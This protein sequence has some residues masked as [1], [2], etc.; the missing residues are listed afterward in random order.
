MN[1]SGQG[2]TYFTIC[3]YEKNPKKCDPNLPTLNIILG[4]IFLIE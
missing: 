1:Q 3:E 2:Y 4:I